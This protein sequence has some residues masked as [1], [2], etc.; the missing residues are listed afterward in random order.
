MASGRGGCKAASK[1]KRCLRKRLYQHLSRHWLAIDIGDLPSKGIRSMVRSALSL[2]NGDVLTR[3]S[4]GHTTA[5]SRMS[6]Q[7][8]MLG[9]ADPR[10]SASLLGRFGLGGRPGSRE[11]CT[12]AFGS[13]PLHTYRRC[14]TR[15]CKAQSRQ[16]SRFPE[17]V[18]LLARPGARPE[19]Q[20]K[21]SGKAPTWQPSS[22]HVEESDLGPC[23]CRSSLEICVKLVTGQ[24]VGLR[25]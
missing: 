8:V 3:S 25:A 23:A 1:P 12:E 10:K 2:P 7:E 16:S 9:V 14:S 17:S 6:A 15:S 21:R 13:L 20:Q 24:P 22:H 5:L 18:T 4:V 19:G 11:V